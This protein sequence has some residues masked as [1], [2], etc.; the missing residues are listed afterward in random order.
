MITPRRSAERGHFNHG[1]LDTYH[2][3]SFADY[4]DPR[5][6]GFRSLRV[7]NEDRVK[8][9][10]GFGE[11]GHR[12]ME[13]IT[14]VVEGGLAHRDSLG[15]GAT[16]RVGEVQRI[17]AGRGITHAEFNASPTDTVH[18]L[19]IWIQPAQRGLEPGYEQRRLDRAA[20]RDRLAAIVTPE[21]KEGTLTVRQD[22][23]LYATILSPGSSVEHVLPRDRYAWVQVVRGGIDL[24]GSALGSGD[25]AAVSDESRIGVRSAGSGEAEV[26]LFDLA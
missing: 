11:H 21:G 8:G 14:Y 24:N 9:G 23:A 25:G 20:M 18:F 2:T 19:Q 26:L 12:D 3:F 15:N 4:H 22:A 7:I 13:I 6:L 17:T 16:I 10:A 1:W 5:H